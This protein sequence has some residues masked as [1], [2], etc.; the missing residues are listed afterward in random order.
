MSFSAAIDGAFDFAQNQ[1]R[2]AWTFGLSGGADA[3][4]PTI[5]HDFIVVNA[6]S[7]FLAGDGMSN[8]FPAR[9]L[10]RAT[11]V[12]H[13]PA[14]ALDPLL[15]RLTESNFLRRPDPGT[16][17]LP[18]ELSGWGSALVHPERENTR[19]ALVT[20]NGVILP[21]AHPQFSLT[22]PNQSPLSSVMLFETLLDKCDDAGGCQ[23]LSPLSMN[24]TGTFGVSGASL[25]PGVTV[26]VNLSIAESEE[27]L[28]R[29]M[30]LRLQPSIDSLVD[31]LY[32]YAESGD[33]RAFPLK[34]YWV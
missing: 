22:A 29:L 8:Q 32:G 12:R 6:M 2:K 27:S 14:V 25:V 3:L 33:G 11:F 21:F 30:A 23:R 34:R 10:M 19:W 15:W 7:R 20:Q 5:A 13:D 28:D 1:L 24:P 26:D 9:V 17:D 31:A 18:P 16:R 4:S